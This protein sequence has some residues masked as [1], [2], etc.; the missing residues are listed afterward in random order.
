MRLTIDSIGIDDALSHKIIAD[1]TTS[2]LLWYFVLD[3][4]E[5]DNLMSVVSE[6]ELCEK[7]GSGSSQKII[8]TRLQRLIDMGLI[9]KDT[10]EFF[11]GQRMPA[12]YKLNLEGRLFVK[13]RTRK[14]IESE[15]IEMSPEVEEMMKYF[16]DKNLEVSQENLGP[17]NTEDRNKQ[18]KACNVLLE[19]RI[20]GEP[21]TLEVFKKV[22]DFM[23]YEL[24]GY[25]AGDKYRMRSFDIHNL[26]WNG[27]NHTEEMKFFKAWRKARHNKQTTNLKEMTDGITGSDR[28]DGSDA[29]GGLWEKV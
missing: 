10:P 8:R 21:M 4:P 15:P 6:K 14:K 22:V 7:L 24:K 13:P 11:G 2:A 12:I 1:P 26:T 27:K 29:G 3:H 28:T 20:N 17:K 5:D 23:A 18:I 19:Q 9:T 25:L 16:F